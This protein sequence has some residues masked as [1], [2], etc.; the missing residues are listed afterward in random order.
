[1]FAR[2]QFTATEE[3]D[4]NSPDEDFESHVDAARY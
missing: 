2:F 4:R 3:C 1:M